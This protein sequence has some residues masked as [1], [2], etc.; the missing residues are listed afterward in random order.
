MSQK[1][2]CNTDLNAGQARAAFQ[3]ARRSRPP[4]LHSAARSLRLSTSAIP[5]P[6]LKSR[7]PPVDSREATAA[8]PTTRS[9]TPV[10]PAPRLPRA[11]PRAMPARRRNLVLPRLRGGRFLRLAVRCHRHGGGQQGQTGLEMEREEACLQWCMAPLSSSRWCDSCVS[12]ATTSRSCEYVHMYI[13]CYLWVW[14][15]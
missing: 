4:P 12:G 7:P 9:Q 1:K 11:G 15:G 3:S 2:N 5:G 6:R 14:Y 13:S 10:G 8:G